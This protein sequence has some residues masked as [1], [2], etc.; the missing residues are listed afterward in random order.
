MPTNQNTTSS[1]N[2]FPALTL[3]QNFRHVTGTLDTDDWSNHTTRALPQ[4]LLRSIQVENPQAQNGV[5]HGKPVR[6]GWIVLLSLLKASVFV[7]A[8]YQSAQPDNYFFPLDRL[9]IKG[10]KYPKIIYF[11]F[12]DK[13]TAQ[14]SRGLA[15][16]SSDSV[17][18]IKLNVFG[19]LWSRKHL[20]YIMK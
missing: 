12:E 13:L 5:P 3:V 16:V 8:E 1:S 11:N 2:S 18:K 6:A 20:F 17:F 19:I 4:Y 9:T 15:P 14:D 7:T 10:S